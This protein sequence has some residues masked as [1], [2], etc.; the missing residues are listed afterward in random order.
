MTTPN[1][2][3]VFPIR[4]GA[5]YELIDERIFQAVPAADDPAG[6]TFVSRDR[7]TTYVLR[8]SDSGGRPVTA[9]WQFNGAGVCPDRGDT[10]AYATPTDFTLWDF[11]EVTP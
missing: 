11:A 1:P 6:V 9:L 10:H 2:R 3:G 5:Q 8:E 7:R 4:P